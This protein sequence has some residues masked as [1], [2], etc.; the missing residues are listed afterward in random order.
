MTAALLCDNTG[1]QHSMPNW[2]GAI[3]LQSVP[4]RRIV[5]R[6]CFEKSLTDKPAQLRVPVELDQRLL[7]LIKTRNERVRSVACLALQFS[8]QEADEQ[9]IFSDPV[10]LL[11]KALQAHDLVPG[12]NYPLLQ[13]AR[14]AIVNR[15]IWVPHGK[16]VTGRGNKQNQ[17]RLR[18]DLRHF[19]APR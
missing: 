10:G 2:I 17:M 5:C 15:G 11:K 19:Q 18:E 4:Y 8:I 13:A 14:Q 1:C 9:G 6:K 12:E 7:K 16:Q 3:E